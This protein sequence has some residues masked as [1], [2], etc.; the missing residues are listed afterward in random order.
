MD[1]SALT[2]GAYLAYVTDTADSPE[3]VRAVDALAMPFPITQGRKTLAQRVYVYASFNRPLWFGCRSAWHEMGVKP[4]SYAELW[5]SL[6]PS[7]AAMIPHTWVVSREEF[8][9][10][11]LKAHELTEIKRPK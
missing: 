2:L 9:A 10:A 1:K 6:T 7:W 3:I 5:P 11:L 8:P 4:G